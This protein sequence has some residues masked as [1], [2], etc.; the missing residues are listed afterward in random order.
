MIFKQI[1]ELI[2]GDKTQ[3]RRLATMKDVFQKNYVTN[4][5]VA[6][7][8]VLSASNGHVKYRQGGQYAIVPKRGQ[9]AIKSHRFYIE[10]IQLELLQEI[11]EEDAVLEGFVLRNGLYQTSALPQ[12][13][14]GTAREGYQA[15]WDSIN[16]K[17]SG[18]RWKDNPLV[19][20]FHLETSLLGEVANVSRE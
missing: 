6:V 2:S 16:G 20:V 10:R 13:R 7:Q 4:T 9:H 11:T 14:F 3:T 5:G 1:E 19:F 8:A 15:L 17:T 12:M 18:A